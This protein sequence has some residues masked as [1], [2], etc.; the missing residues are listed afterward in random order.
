ML[1]I[2]TVEAEKLSFY[3]NLLKFDLIRKYVYLFS[4]GCASQ[5]WSS[6]FFGNFPVVMNEIAGENVFSTVR[7][8]KSVGGHGK[9][10]IIRLFIRI[11]KCTNL[12]GLNF[13]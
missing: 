10:I 5:N 12:I 13:K 1:K 4:D 9:G 3:E 6:S 8:M 11:Y 7:M 2:I